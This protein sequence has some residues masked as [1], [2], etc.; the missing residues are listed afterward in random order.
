MKSLKLLLFTAALSLPSYAQTVADFYEKALDAFKEEK[1]QD[2]YIY[3]KNAL[4]QDPDHLP[5]KLLMGR[6]LLM[7]GFIPDS[8]DEF[9][10]AL[11]GGADKNLV[12]PFLAQAYLL[13]GLYHKV[14]DLYTEPGLTE[15]VRLNLLLVS[16]EA[17]VRQGKIED[18]IKL[19]ES[20]LSKYANKA[21]LYSTLASRYISVDDLSNAE[22]YLIKALTIGKQSPAILYT[23]GRLEEAKG[24][25]AKALEIFEK[26]DQQDP[27]NPTYM[28]TLATTY[29]EMEEFDR[30]NDIVAKIELQTPG[31]VQNKLLKARILALTNQQFEA[32]K[33]LQELTNEFSLLTEQQ[34]NERIQ[35]SLITGIVGYIN[36]SY[37]LASTELARYLSERKPTV[38]IIGM[39]ADSL[40]RLGYYKDAVKILEKHQD[41]I[42]NNIEV[43]ALTC[44]LYI[45][46]NR[47]FKCEALV[48]KLD[49]RYPGHTDVT[50]IKTKLLMDRGQYTEAYDYLTS[51]TTDSARLDV[52][53]LKILLLANLG[54]FTDAYEQAGKLLDED[55]DNIGYQVIYADIAVR[56]NRLDTA[57]AYV[58]KIIKVDPKNVGALVTKARIQFA[59]EEPQPAIITLDSILQEDKR[60]VSALL[61]SAQIHASE[62]EYEQAINQLLT[63]KEL[64]NNSVK[65]RQLLV[66]VYRE[67]RDWE[68]ALA[69]INQLLSIRRLSTDYLIQKAEILISMNREKEARSQLGAVFGQWA[70]EP[71]KL[72]ALSKLQMRA[73]DYEGAEK[74]LLAAIEKVPNQP[75]F[76]L[77]YIDLLINQKALDKAKGEIKTFISLFGKTANSEMLEGDFAFAKGN[78][79]AA[80]AHYLASSKLDGNFQ[81]PILK[82]YQLVKEGQ[83]LDAFLKHIHSLLANDG[84]NHLARHLLADTLFS[85]GQY[86]E[87]I[88]QYNMLLEV[89]DLPRKSYI[90][91]NLAIIYKDRDVE[92]AI[93]Y[94][95]LALDLTPDSAAILDTKGWLLTLNGD[96]QQGLALLRE[97]YTLNS[98]DPSTHYHIAY[99]LNATGKRDEAYTILSS[100]NT[101]TKDFTELE[102]AK[103]L[104]QSLEDR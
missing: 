95:D 1:I 8:I 63:A 68:G 100:N 77:E 37:D 38:E 90:Y 30:A 102:K 88:E 53:K 57:T 9:E 97:A 87:A 62:R 26:V 80:F 40:L 56:L 43:A 96:Y 14:V 25:K 75:T 5:S 32:D 16:S 12:L 4:Q 72:S 81:R 91:N 92:Q 103:A 85:N 22:A 89:D 13:S 42:L 60:N 33:I 70:E 44:E 66:S 20:N 21:S 82:M 7:D 2:S 52:T 48:P 18:S 69:E 46:I 49:M 11:L 17:K 74:S 39:L 99:N 51:A 28:R 59:Q 73:N 3:T 34:R 31:D 24:N 19:L 67:Q 55:P 104:Y 61:L 36:K 15:E 35:L 47:S 10:E 94:S 64:S 78:R 45:A 101:L 76:R 41:I 93:K 29:A 54:N 6:I 27:D 98:S 83:P 23:R 79:K 84:D 65:P 86:A 58:N 50:L 71:Y